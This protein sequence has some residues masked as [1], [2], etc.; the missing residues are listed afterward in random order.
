MSYYT[1]R[2]NS[3]TKGMSREYLFNKNNSI[4]GEKQKGVIEGNLFFYPQAIVFQENFESYAPKG[5][6]TFPDSLGY[7]LDD[8]H[9]WNIADGEKVDSLISGENNQALYFKDELGVGDHQESYG[10]DIKYSLDRFSFSC[11]LTWDGENE[12]RTYQSHVTLRGYSGGIFYNI[13][14][15]G[16]DDFASTNTGVFFISFYEEDG[17]SNQRWSSSIGEPMTDDSVTISITRNSSNYIDASI[18]TFSAVAV[19]NN[20]NFTNFV[21][22]AGNG[23]SSFAGSEFWYDDILISGMVGED[24]DGDGLSNIEETD[25]YGTNPY[26]SD[27]D[28]DGL[29]DGPEVYSHLTDPLNEDTDE[30]GLLDGEEV[31]NYQTNPLQEDTDEDGID[32]YD[33][34]YNHPTDPTKADSDQDGILDGEELIE[35]EDNYITDPMDSD[36]DDDGLLDGEEVDNWQ[37]DPNNEDTDQDG[38]TDYEEVIDYQTDPNSEDSDQDGYTDKEEID[39]DKD[40][41]DPQSFPYD[42][43]FDGLD[44]DE[45]IYVYFTDPENNDTDSDQLEDGAEVHTHLTDPLNNDTDGDQIIDG[46]EVNNFGTN[47]LN[48]DTDSDGL[49]DYE[50]LFIA[51]TNPTRVD[52]DG[53]GLSD[54][55]EFEY[56]LT[57]PNDPDTDE[58]ELSDSEEIDF[59]TDPLNS[60]S[61]GDGLSDGIE[62]NIQGTNPNDEDTDGDGLS[63]GEEVNSFETNPLNVDSDDDIMD[64]Y[65]EIE[66]GLDPNDPTDATLDNDGD[67]LTNLMEYNHNCN[68]NERDSDDDGLSDQQ[69]I[70]IYGTDPT[71]SDSDGDGFSD[72]LEIQKNTDP[73]D[74]QST[75]RKKVWTI[76]GIVLGLI[77]F[78]GIAGFGI[79]MAIR[80]VPEI[81]QQRQLAREEEIKRNERA[82]FDF[83]AAVP[84]GY[85]TDSQQLAEILSIPQSEVVQL[86]NLWFNSGDIEKIGSYN[87]LEDR[88]RKTV[89]TDYREKN[90]TCFYCHEEISGEEIIC[91]HCNF[92]II[93]C[94][95]CNLPLSH[96]DAIGACVFCNTPAHLEHLK[97]H[98]VLRNHCPSCHR[99]ITPKNVKIITRPTVSITQQESTDSRRRIIWPWKSPKTETIEQKNIEELQEE[100]ISREPL[101]EKD[102]LKEST[103]DQSLEE[104]KT[105]TTIEKQD[106]TILSEEEEEELETRETTKPETPDSSIE[107]KEK[108]KGKRK[109]SSKKTKKKKVKKSKKSQPKVQKDTKKSTPPLN[110]QDDQ[111]NELIELDIELEEID[112]GDDLE[113]IPDNGSEEIIIDP[114]YG[115]EISFDD[116]EEITP[117][118]EEQETKSKDEK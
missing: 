90:I 46:E 72:G 94:P 77:F 57:D 69:E 8:G 20:W 87:P 35:G 42:L 100:Q 83:L 84:I 33:E 70:N 78:I 56:Y 9:W 73:L 58:D 109:S 24:D 71:N 23:M 61:D 27:S 81:Q 37:T 111:D 5:S 49:T 112:L 44:D 19:A 104:D 60:D 59:N 50:E 93:R 114:K 7:Q 110:L 102:E 65:Y 86:L 64:D 30:D 11:N 91:P 85:E 32:D 13:L 118:S 74:P 4:L 107:K 115:E 108:R 98:A 40:P 82:L 88:F 99:R 14:R 51:E 28:N 3:F 55:E 54:Q 21:V 17:I 52:S 79:L 10:A 15:I 92:E 47:P 76:V 95:V 89:I 62:V 48:N 66:Y 53:D 105:E 75:P 31:N 97:Q 113:E 43:D 36:C 2:E 63:D 106:S 39:Q 96:D 80:K 116:L 1:I 26:D 18:G 25:T 41:N 22:E 45:E 34:V 29:E 101:S 68:P 103:E 38:L 117:H 12:S 16:I 67:G 6:T